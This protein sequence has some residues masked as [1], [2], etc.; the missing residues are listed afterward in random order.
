MKRL[1]KENERISTILAFL[2]IPLS[3]MAMDIYLPSFPHM[4]T[5]LGTTAENI[6]LSLSIYLISYGV[7]QLF[8]GSLVDSLGRYKINIICL[9][10]F[11]LSCLGIVLSANIYFI[12]LMRFIQGITISFIVVC[13]RS[14]FIDVYTGKK[15]KHYTS[16]ITMVWATGPILAP[17]IGGY[18]QQNFGWRANFWLLAGYGTVM[19]LLEWIYSGETIV[20]K[21]PL[22]WKAMLQNYKLLLQHRDLSIGTIL[23]GM[24][25]SMVMI[26]GMSIPFIVEQKFH[27]TSVYSGYC[28]LVSGLAIFFGGMLGKFTIDK[29]FYPKLALANGIQVSL[30]LMMMVSA[31][32]I[33]GLLPM[34][35]FVFLIHLFQGFTY[36]VYFTYCLTRFPEFAATTSGIS[37]GG[38]YLIFSIMSYFI[39]HAID[40]DGQLGL[41]IAY[42]CCLVFVFGLLWVIKGVL[43]QGKSAE[44][45]H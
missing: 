43:Q 39:V 4:A 26:F 38:S 44:L 18:L 45:A 42:M 33:S 19:L 11:I 10:L 41:S 1:K 7:S 24:S 16:I 25:Y 21:Q 12:F 37:S 22:R 3:G 17:F 8:V 14:F 15:R 29:P 6:K 2:L 23:L 20:V 40:V 34:M 36:T 27:L 30:A 9:F 5:D 32:W 35:V 31:Q 13:K 28:A